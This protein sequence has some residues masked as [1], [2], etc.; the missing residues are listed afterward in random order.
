MSDKTEAAKII[1]QRKPKTMG[2]IF[3]CARADGKT[4]GEAWDIVD[5][6]Y[7]NVRNDK[8]YRAACGY[9]Q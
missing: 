9:T 5:A 3:D 7:A 4:I 2:G 8:D 6:H 1:R